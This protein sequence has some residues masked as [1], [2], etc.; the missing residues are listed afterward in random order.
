MLL[1]KNLN[2]NNFIAIGTDNASVMV[3]INNAIY[4]KLKQENPFLIL[5]RCVCH[6]IQLAM[7]YASAECLP[8]NLEYLIAITHN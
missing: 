7:S 3:G 5:M 6:S 2:I 1:T 4:S 8:M